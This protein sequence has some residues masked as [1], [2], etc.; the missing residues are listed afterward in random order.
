MEDNVRNKFSNA[1]W[2]LFFVAI[3]VGIAGNVLDI[4]DF[5]LFFEGWWTFLIIVPCF[6]SMLQSGFGVASTMGFIIGVLLFLQSRVDFNLDLWQLIIPVILVF[7]GIRIMFQG[8]FRKRTKFF[9]QNINVNGGAQQTFNGAAKSEYSAV[10]SSNRIHVTEVFSGTNLNAVFGGL[11]LDLRDARIPG[12]V[13]VNATAIFG[14]I[15]IYIPRGVN[16]KTNNVPIFGGISNKTNQT[17]EP[18]APTIYLN[19]TCMFG[20]IDIK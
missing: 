17:A 8:A 15:D 20:G 3:G 4:W 19:A 5:Q 7:I 12:D 14:G 6:I 16:I 9:E 13:E 11:V 2:G 18:G 1:L 10:F